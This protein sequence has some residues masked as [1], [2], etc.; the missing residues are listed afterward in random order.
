M[1]D[2][3]QP[4]DLTPDAD[5]PDAP[6]SQSETQPADA[7]TQPADATPDAPTDTPTDAL[8]EVEESPLAALAGDPAGMVEAVLFASDAPLTAGKIADVTAMTATVVKNAIDELNADYDERKTSFHIKPLAGGFQMQTRPEFDAVLSRL[9]AD[10]KD[11]KLSQAAM[12]TLAI[13]AYRQPI[14]RANV[15]AIRGVACGEVLRGLME[16]QMVKIVGRADVL[17][18]PMLYGTTRKFLEMFG[19]SSLNDLPNSE[20]LRSKA[21]DPTTQPP[22]AEESDALEEEAEATQDAPTEAPES[23]TPEP[24]TEATP[25]PSDR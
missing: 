14:L 19:L 9:L 2:S 7:D 20:D 8:T 17:G 22:A 6:A 21:Y 23:V 16:K 4:D 5:A 1:N 18:R 12:E 11:S 24:E 3:M 13:I 15:E 25:E 10:R